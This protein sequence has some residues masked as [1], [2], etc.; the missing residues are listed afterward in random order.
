[1]SVR[2]IGRATRYAGLTRVGGGVSYKIANY[3]FIKKYE[4]SAVES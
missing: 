1:M 3:K 2:M 4:I